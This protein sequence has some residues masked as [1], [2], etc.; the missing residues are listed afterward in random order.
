MKAVLCFSYLVIMGISIFL[1]G[2]FFPRKWIFENAFPYK[3]FAFEKNGTVYEKVNIKK[4]KTKWPDA[5][6][7][8][9]GFFGE[10]YPK[11][12]IEGKN[13]EKIQ[14]LIKETCIAES[15]HFMAIILGL[16]SIKIWFNIGGF[17]IW[18]AWLGWNLPPILIQRY[19][20]P[21]LKNIL[22][23]NK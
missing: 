22:K 7:I 18:L 15:T 9:H 17:M 19:N 16:F 1:C 23:N 14:V 3:S 10:F 11:K 20:R 13:L 2:R 5:S 6:K 4:W 12:Q 8:F 21:R